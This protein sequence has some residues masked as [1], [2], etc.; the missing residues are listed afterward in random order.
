MCQLLNKIRMQQSISSGKDVTIRQL[1]K[2]EAMHWKGRVC[3]LSY[4]DVT[5]F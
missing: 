5:Q 3:H 1:G 4:I 2:D